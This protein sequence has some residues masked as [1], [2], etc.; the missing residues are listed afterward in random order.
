MPVPAR[1]TR[2]LPQA[3]MTGAISIVWMIEGRVVQRGS[4]VGKG[5]SLMAP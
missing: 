1:M 5:R 4:G 2:T 3:M